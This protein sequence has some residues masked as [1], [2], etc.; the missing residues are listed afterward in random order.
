[1]HITD[2]LLKYRLPLFDQAGEGG[3]G[4]DGGSDAGGAD[5]GSQGA[6]AGTG[7]TKTILG[8]ENQNT[9][10]TGTD[11]ADDGGK[12]S[13]GKTKDGEGDSKDEP[14]D[15]TKDGDKEDKTDQASTEIK[16]EAPEGMEAFQGEFDT[17]STEAT[18][19]MKENPTAT[20]ADAFKWA[21]ERQAQNVSTQTQETADGL[22]ETIKGWETGLKSDKDIGGD[23][24]D[25]NMA[26]AAKTTAAYGSEEIVG[27]LNETGLGSHPAFVKMF[28]KIGLTL[29]DADVHMGEGGNKDAS[30]EQSLASRYP[31]SKSS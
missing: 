24:Y 8:G 14:S 9:D 5:A 4:A 22:N 21:A 15:D 31:K 16:L 23:A 1:M 11:G 13:E 7:D 10:D 12:D 19:W 26:I 20:A 30:R 3:G 2:M 18:D 25:A 29:K 28:H 27:I 6:D 17:F